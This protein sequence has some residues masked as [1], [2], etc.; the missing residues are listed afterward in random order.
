[1]DHIE[2]VLVYLFNNQL[3]CAFTPDVVFVSHIDF[4][5][6]IKVAKLLVFLDSLHLFLS[7][8]PFEFYSFV[9]A[10]FHQLADYFVYFK[11]AD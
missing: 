6:D 11:A 2:W 10:V 7:L 8:L 4:G 5:I 1:M 3:Y 9:L